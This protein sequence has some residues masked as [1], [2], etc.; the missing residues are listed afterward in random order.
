MYKTLFELNT[1][2]FS[3]FA[4]IPRS[5]RNTAFDPYVITML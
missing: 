1:L 3:G 5:F 2:Q 4:T